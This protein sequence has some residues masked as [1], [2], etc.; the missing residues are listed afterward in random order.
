MAVGGRKIRQAE[1]SIWQ[2][3]EE[4]GG[5][6]RVFFNNAAPLLE[7]S[8]KAGVR[9]ETVRSDLGG[10]FQRTGEG[11]LSK[12]VAGFLQG[13]QPTRHPGGEGTLLG[14]ARAR[15]AVPDKH[16]PGRRLWG[17]FAAIE[18]NEASIRFPDQKETPA[19]DAGI[20]AIHHS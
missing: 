12:R 17:F 2:R 15:L 16:I 1:F 20:M 3:S 6:G 5:G 4:D 18:T 19:A 8:R 10:S 11:K 13:R 9:S 14:E 7:P